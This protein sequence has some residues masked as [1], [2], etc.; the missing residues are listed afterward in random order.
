VTLRFL[1]LRNPAR[2]ASCI[3]GLGLFS[4]VKYQFA[5]K[6][7]V[8]RWGLLVQPREG[9]VIVRGGV[10]NLLRHRYYAFNLS[11]LNQIFLCLERLDVV[12]YF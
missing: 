7:E 10:F 5:L 6:F 8:A 11:A 9:L 4:H 12:N 3:I 1:L 2:Y